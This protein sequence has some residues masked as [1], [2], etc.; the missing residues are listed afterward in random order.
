MV[1]SLVIF[2]FALFF[3]VEGIVW[4]LNRTAGPREEQAAPRQVLRPFGEIH[5][6]RG[7]F[8]ADNHAWVRLSES[9]EF[10]VG[11]DEFLAE[12]LGGAD[13]VE[14]PE[15]GAEV[16]KGE[17]LAKIWRH[18]RVLALPAPVDGTVMQV[19]ARL[20]EHPEEL[21]EDPYG[22]AWVAAMLPVE[23]TEALR[24]LRLGE[25]ARQWLA[26]EVQRFVEFLARRSAPQLVG[27]TI[28]DGA[29][30]VIGAALA[31]D[32]EGWREF[33]REFVER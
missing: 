29:R 30:P 14:L 23:P 25:R 21:G 22:N 5:L 7:L 18:G 3:L 11:A 13:R 28:P 26:R 1:V 17:S 8:V 9:G 16:R 6:P 20:A 33:R 32:D 10:R 15:V 24:E 4:A 19:N 31:L 27:A 12:A 2:T